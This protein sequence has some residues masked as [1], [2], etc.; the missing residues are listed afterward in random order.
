MP[1]R[2]VGPALRPVSHTGW[3]RGQRLDLLKSSFMDGH[4]LIPETW[5]NILNRLGDA[6]G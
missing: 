3:K 4:R 2:G 6:D 5:K 1:L